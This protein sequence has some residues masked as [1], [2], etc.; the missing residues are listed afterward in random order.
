MSDWPVWARV[1]AWFVGFKPLERFASDGMFAD[2]L[3]KV[4]LSPYNDAGDVVSEASGAYSPAIDED[5]L[6]LEQRMRRRASTAKKYGLMRASASAERYSGGTDMRWGPLSQQYLDLVKGECYVCIETLDKQWAYVVELADVEYLVEEGGWVPCAYLGERIGTLTFY[7]LPVPTEVKE[8]P[9]EVRQ[10]EVVL[11]PSARCIQVYV[12]GSCD[13]SNGI[14][15]AWKFGCGFVSDRASLAS[16][17]N[18]SEASELLGIVGGMM[19][20]YWHREE[21]DFC[22]LRV[23]SRNAIEHVFRD[24]TP[25]SDDGRDLLPGIFL[26]RDLVRKLRAFGKRVECMKVHRKRNPAHHVALSEVRIRR[27]NEWLKRDD[28]WPLPEKFKEV[29]RAMARNRRYHAEVVCIPAA[30]ARYVFDLP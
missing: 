21:Y 11:P 6:T 14:A 20:I 9:K 16:S 10:Y 8:V 2:Y 25:A 4:G 1:L 12:D 26:A 7:E 22:I 18:G 27:E 28:V 17:M 19:S 15:G 30:A 23:D 3:E 24:L 5:G 13:Q 29:F